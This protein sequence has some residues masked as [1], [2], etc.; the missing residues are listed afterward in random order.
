MR[1]IICFSMLGVRPRASR[2]S[3]Q[4]LC[5]LT[6]FQVWVIIKLLSWRNFLFFLSMKQYVSCMVKLMVVREYIQVCVSYL[7]WVDKCKEVV[8]DVVGRKQ[9]TLLSLSTTWV[10]LSTLNNYVDYCDYCVNCLHKYQWN[11]V[12]TFGLCVVYRKYISVH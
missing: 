11:M 6:T 9:D 10:Q 7:W 12:L 1:V 5:H 4:E 8:K 2:H 3:R